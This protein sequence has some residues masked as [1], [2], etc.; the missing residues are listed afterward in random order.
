MISSPSSTDLAKCRSVALQLL[1]RVSSHYWTA[2][3][4]ENWAR[5]LRVLRK[6]R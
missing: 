3:T 6:R 4:E 2:S 5:L 1:D